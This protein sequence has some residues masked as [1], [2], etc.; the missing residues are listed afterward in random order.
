MK[1]KGGK[2]LTDAL[3]RVTK[4]VNNNNNNISQKIERE[5]VETEFLR[6]IKSNE[7]QKEIEKKVVF[8]LSFVIFFLFMFV[9]FRLYKPETQ[10]GNGGKWR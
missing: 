6:E 8:V 3:D 4:R 7:P 10:G 5:K 2:K 1:K 9:R